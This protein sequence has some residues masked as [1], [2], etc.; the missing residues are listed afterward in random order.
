MSAFFDDVILQTRSVNYWISL[1]IANRWVFE[2]L[3]MIA[4]C[5]KKSIVTIMD[6]VTLFCV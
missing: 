2:T 5:E 6:A 4:Y 1:Y 3:Y